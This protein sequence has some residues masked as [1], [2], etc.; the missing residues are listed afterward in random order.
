MK[1]SYKPLHIL[2]SSVLIK[3]I[4]KEEDQEKAYALLE[5][6]YKKEIELGIPTLAYYE[7]LN[8]LSRAIPFQS[9]LFFSQIM[10]MKMSE[11][12]INLE[13]VSETTEITQKFPKAAFYDATYHALA[14]SHNGTF[15]TAD[16]KYYNLAK[17]LKHIKLLK[18]YK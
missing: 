2:D 16:E 4:K 15:I 1:D 12:T 6:F 9:I 3:L 14:I 10:T 5:K 11:F 17:S 8:Y 18:D 7:V 13:N